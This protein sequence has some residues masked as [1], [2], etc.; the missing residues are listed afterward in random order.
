[1]QP[2]ETSSSATRNVPRVSVLL[3]VQNDEQSLTK[4]L[5]SLSNQILD[6]LEIIAIDDGSTDSSTDVLENYAKKEPRLKIAK[7]KKV[8]FGRS[9]SQGIK[10]AHGEYV[11]FITPADLL[12]PATYIELFAL[13]K[14]H[15]ADLVRSNFYEEVND[16][17]IL[18]EPISKEEADLLIDPT[19][20]THIFY[21]P[22]AL[23]SALYRREYL[24]QKKLDFLKSKDN[25]YYATS[26]NFKTLVTTSK[27]VLT[28][29][30][31]A[32][33][34]NSTKN[35]SLFSI[36]AEYTEIENYLKDKILWKTYCYVFQAVKFNSYYK[37]LQALPKLEQE[38]FVLR[39]RAE[40]HDADNH[41]LLAKHYF[42][43]DQWHA[44]NQILNFPPKIFLATLKFKHKN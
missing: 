33:H 27:I 16:K 3:Y 4:C 38:K 17:E 20:N 24:L 5:V 10:A 18:Q 25:P 31:Y 35:L 1:M 42:P 14:K 8:G 32:H 12:D 23:W 37:H 7:T 26:F 22:P 41:R 28:E 13:A 15:D 29:K 2:I 40:F 39:T 6:D 9:A 19:E 30:V 43:K 11:S 44:L 34:K 21:R 36:N